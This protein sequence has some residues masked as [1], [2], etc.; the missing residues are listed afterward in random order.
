MNSNIS[1]KLKETSTAKSV[2]EG[3]KPFKCEIEN[4]EYASKSRNEFNCHTLSIH[5]KNKKPFLCT[6]CGM[7]FIAKGRLENHVGSVHEKKKDFQCELCSAGFACIS[8][9]HGHMKKFH[10]EY[11]VSEFR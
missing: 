8:Y 7:S 1:T 3:Y 5:E 4:C 9:L 2:H 6:E 11:A 10:K